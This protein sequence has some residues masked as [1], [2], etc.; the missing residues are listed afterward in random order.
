MGRSYSIYV[1]A[2]ASQWQ[3]GS[4]NV[5][6]NRLSVQGDID[7]VRFSATGSPPLSQRPALAGWPTKNTISS[8]IGKIIAVAG[9]TLVGYDLTNAFFG[10]HTTAGGIQ[11]TW[12]QGA[13]W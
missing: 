5:N 7:K 12:N 8:T 4:A 3:V 2:F 9:P 11:Y 13:G 6:Y 10:S 1:I